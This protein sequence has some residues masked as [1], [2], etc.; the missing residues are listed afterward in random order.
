MKKYIALFLTL[1]LTFGLCSCDN[2]CVCN[3]HPAFPEENFELPQDNSLVTYTLSNGDTLTMLYND[4]HYNLYTNLFYGEWKHGDEVTRVGAIE[5]ALV[6]GCWQH[7]QYA[8]GFTL[9]LFEISGLALDFPT[10]NYFYDTLITELAYFDAGILNSTKLTLTEGGEE[11][12]IVSTSVDKAQFTYWDWNDPGWS[13]FISYG[14]DTRIVVDEIE[15]SYH[16]WRNMGEMKIGEETIPIKLVIY[17]EAME[18]SV[19]D[20]SNHGSEFIM[21]LMGHMS[22]ENAS[23]F[24][25]DKIECAWRFEQKNEFSSLKDIELKRIEMTED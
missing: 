7:G 18:I 13:D 8:Y 19:Y 22:A 3:D 17:E 11:L 21:H 12:N 14:E 10:T 1:L 24:V 2:L 15:L 23:V 16:P 20:M 5:R 6:S 4:Q 9:Q 25:I